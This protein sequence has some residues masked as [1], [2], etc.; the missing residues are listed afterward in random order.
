[1][2]CH[3]RTRSRLRPLPGLGFAILL[4]TAFAGSSGSLLAA[5]SIEGTWKLTQYL[6]PNNTQVPALAS[7]TPTATFAGGMITG[8]T[9]CNSFTASYTVSGSTLTIKPGIMSLVGCQGPVGTQ[10]QAFMANLNT[11]TGFT[12][13]GSTLT[14]TNASG[15]AVLTFTDATPGGSGGATTLPTTGNARQVRTLPWEALGLFA[16]AL[17]VV[18]GYLVWRRAI[19]R[20]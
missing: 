5:T 12:I 9:G 14:L 4:I 8:T 17:T 15:A 20:R 6:G 10:E 3:V 7:A 11:V 18:A 1:M 16:G 13:T 2:H 19:A